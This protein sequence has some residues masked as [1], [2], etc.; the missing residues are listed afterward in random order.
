[1]FPFSPWEEPFWIL[2]QYSGVNWKHGSCLS[3]LLCASLR[4]EK[5]AV[6]TLCRMCRGLYG[7]PRFLGVRISGEMF[8]VSCM[9][10]GGKFGA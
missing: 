6:C 5:F 1:M 8:V 7:E 9:N 3:T 2:A 4:K 10:S